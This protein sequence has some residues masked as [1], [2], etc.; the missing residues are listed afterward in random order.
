[1]ALNF[2]TYIYDL[3]LDLVNTIYYLT[4]PDQNTGSVELNAF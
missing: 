3:L 2:K 4:F 1:M